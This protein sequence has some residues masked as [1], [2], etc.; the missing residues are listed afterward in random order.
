MTAEDLNDILRREGP[1]AIRA[2]P[3]PPSLFAGDGGIGKS[4][5]TNQIAISSALG[6]QWL[7]FDVLKGRPLILSAEDGE[8]VLQLRLNEIVTQETPFAMRDALEAQ[9]NIFII[10]ATR[11]GGRLVPPR[12]PC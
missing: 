1:D 9:S 7:G 12:E 11:E 2:P 4:T 6:I 8:D 5:L 10:D 3:Y